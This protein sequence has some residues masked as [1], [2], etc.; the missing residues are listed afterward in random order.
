MFS[1]KH[2]FEKMDSFKVKKLKEDNNPISFTM[3]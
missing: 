1:E 2:S 3:Q